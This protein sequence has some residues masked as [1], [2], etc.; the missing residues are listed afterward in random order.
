MVAD[1]A[2]VLTVVNQISDGPQ[3][4]IDGVPQG[5]TVHRI[6]APLWLFASWT[7]WSFGLPRPTRWEI[8]LITDLME[9]QPFLHLACTPYALAYAIRVAR[10]AAAE[11]IAPVPVPASG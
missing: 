1:L 6:S 7:D 8:F 2:V 3:T 4:V 9:F 10:P 11:P 5:D